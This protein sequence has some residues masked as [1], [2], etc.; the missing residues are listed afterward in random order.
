MIKKNET[1]RVCKDKQSKMTASPVQG[2]L[3][4]LLED[5]T[6]HRAT[7]DEEKVVGRTMVGGECYLTGSMCEGMEV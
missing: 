7:E 3:A 2:K 6:C 5:V 1:I 4:V